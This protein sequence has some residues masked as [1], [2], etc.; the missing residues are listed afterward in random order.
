MRILK[1]PCCKTV[2]T[3]CSTLVGVIYVQVI[4]QDKKQSF[5]LSKALL[6]ERAPGFP[7]D[8]TKITDISINAFERF[9]RWLKKDDIGIARWHEWKGVIFENDVWNAALEF[10]QLHTCGQKYKVQELCRYVFHLFT[11]CLSVLAEPERIKCLPLDNV[12][13]FA[14]QTVIEIYTN[15]AH[16]SP[17]RKVLIDGICADNF[18]KDSMRGNILEFPPEFLAELLCRMS[19]LKGYGESIADAREKLRNFLR[20]QK[21]QQEKNGTNTL[22]DTPLSQLNQSKAPEQEASKNGMENNDGDARKR[23]KI[24]ALEDKDLSIAQP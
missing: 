7:Y 9:V 20:D 10:A 3:Y 21:I 13:R 16:D 23:R 12:P 11:R 2:L 4:E 22:R 15:S 14:R 18:I 6:E 1:T 17:L 8:N 24:G 19:A 5:Y